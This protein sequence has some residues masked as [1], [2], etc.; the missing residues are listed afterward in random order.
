MSEPKI[1][2]GIGTVW[3]VWHDEYPPDGGN[4]VFLAAY[5]EKHAE[6]SAKALVDIIKRAGATGQVVASPVLLWPS[7]TWDGVAGARTCRV[8]PSVVAGMVYCTT[9]RGTWDQSLG[10]IGCTS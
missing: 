8:E 6:Q 7:V 1:A 3:I 5:D 4:P 10:V 2:D 9:C